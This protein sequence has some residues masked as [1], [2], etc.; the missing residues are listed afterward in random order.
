M[1]AWKAVFELPRYRRTHGRD[2]IF[3]D[4][5]PGFV[6]HQLG[7]SFHDA[8]CNEMRRSVQLLVDLPQRSF[9]TEYW[10]MRTLI[11]TPNNPSVVDINKPDV[12]QTFARRRVPLAERDKLLYFTGACSNYDALGKTFR[13]GVC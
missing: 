7:H 2:F 3:Y 5:H 13:W 9:C 4:A 1:Q 11:V 12:A 8:Q 10:N 6:E